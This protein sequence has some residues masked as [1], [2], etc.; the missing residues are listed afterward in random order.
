[1]DPNSQIPPNQPIDPDQIDPAVELARSKIRSINGQPEPQ[2]PPVEPEIAATGT[3]DY[4]TFSLPGQPGHVSQPEPNPVQQQ[5]QPPTEDLFSFHA[6]QQA[7]P[8]DNSIQTPHYPPSNQ[9]LPP[10]E[11][12]TQQHS[13]PINQLYAQ[14]ANLQHQVDQNYQAPA[15][16]DHQ[17]PPANLRFELPLGKKGIPS[18]LMPFVKTL[19]FA[20]IIS[21][22][23]NHQFILG[24]VHHYVNP[25]QSVVSPQLLDPN[26]NAKVDKDST[27]LIIPKINLEVPVVYDVKSYKDADVQVGLQRGV[28]HYGE[29]AL[30]GEVGNNTIVGHSSTSFWN[31]GDFKFAFV[32]LDRLEV[33]DTFVLHY[34]GT[35]YVYEVFQRRI[36]KPTDVY[37]AFEDFGEPVTTLITCNPPGLGVNRLVVNARQISPDPNNAKKPSEPFVQPTNDDIIPGQ[38]ASLIDIVRGW[39]D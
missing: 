1:M 13:Q 35:R 18:R 33:G 4:E 31:A 11:P 19:I 21:I 2:T 6:G 7:L 23:Y 36:V 28:V 27:K 22:V 20:L 3:T 12:F 30:P 29:T 15:A 34:K 24:Q 14:E 37:V 8:V 10:E 32:L 17:L 25:S 16:V 5:L 26:V 39:F 38:P 9:P